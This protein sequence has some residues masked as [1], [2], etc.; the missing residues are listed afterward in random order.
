MRKAILPIGI[1]ASLIGAAWGVAAAQSLPPGPYSSWSKQQQQ[2]AANSLKEICAKVCAPYT[3]AT[4]AGGIRASYEAA[5]CTSAGF[6]NRLPKDYPGLPGIKQSADQNY[7]QAKKLGSNAPV[8]VEKNECKM[9]VPGRVVLSVRLSHVA[10]ISAVTFIVLM[11]FGL[12]GPLEDEMRRMQA[13]K[14]SFRLP[15]PMVSPAN[16]APYSTD[17]EREAAQAAAKIGPADSETE[18]DASQAFDD[19][20]SQPDSVNL[21]FWNSVRDYARQ[22]ADAIRDFPFHNPFWAPS[23]VGDYTEALLVPSGVWLE[24]KVA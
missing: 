19:P 17:F 20:G 22:V 10:V 8:F 3:A 24:L 14:R 2:Q 16:P 7:E 9:F 21:Q 13:P 6:Y 12:A 4:N 5:A 15:A 11:H 1:A 18:A 23:I